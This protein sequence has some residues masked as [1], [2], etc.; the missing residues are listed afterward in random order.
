MAQYYDE[1]HR[2]DLQIGKVMESLQ[3]QGLLENT[4]VIVMSDN[5]S[6]FWK[7]KK[8]LTDPGLK[9]PFIVHWPAIIKQHQDFRE[10]VSA[11][12][13]APT[14]LELAGIEIPPQMEGSSFAHWL[15]DP[16]TATQPIR[17]FC[18]RRA[19]RCRA[20]FG[21]WSQYSRPKIF[22][23]RRRSRYLHRV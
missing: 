17:D 14:V 15:K 10:L 9:T 2:V 6:P 16:A 5:G 11:V 18:L 3:R 19:R 20:E 22:I 8:F 7:A 12:D 21:K 4:V 13:I 23:Y 1:I